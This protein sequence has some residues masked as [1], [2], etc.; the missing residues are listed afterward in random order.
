MEY[1]V[2]VG[3]EVHVE[4]ATQS[5]IFCSCSTAFGAPPNTQCCP[6]CLGLP[7]ALPQ[8]NEKVLDYSILAGLATHCRIAE[9][10]QFDRKHYFYPDLPKAYQI[11]QYEMPLCRDGYLKVETDA[12]E[13]IIRIERIHMEEDAGKLVHQQAG[14]TLID[15]NRCG[16]PL[17]EIVS[18][19]DMNSAQE[20]VAYLK[21]LRSVLVYAG[22]TD[23]NMSQG[24]F[25]ADINL[26]LR[27]KGDSALGTRTEIKN[28]N[29]FGYVSKAIAYEARRQAELLRQGLVVEQ[30]TRRFDA[31]SGTTRSLRQK[32]EAA[33][34]RFMP[35]PDLPPF[36][37]SRARVEAL[38]SSMPLLPDERKKMY[39][40]TYQLSA[41]HS[42]QLILEKEV[43]DLFEAAAAQSRYP[44]TV[45]SL[46]LAE[47]LRLYQ[48][49]QG[50]PLPAGELAA[51]A[52]C[53]G[54]GDIHSGAAREVLGKIWH[55]GGAAREWIDRLGLHQIQD[56]RQLGQIAA[57]VLEQNP[58]LAEDY[59]SGKTRAL[60]A[61][62]G[63][64]MAQT[65][66][67][68]NP[69]LLQNLLLEML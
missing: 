22:I 63:K 8:F 26:S 51:L 62:M 12:G 37:L 3:I 43:A 25:R 31:A 46:L 49:E 21:K 10:T 47:V 19:P 32:G 5:K 40:E 36:A 44:Q 28:I 68:A 50:L 64:A 14:S 48:P 17:I 29:S 35:E 53:T 67:R 59:R 1:E 57:Q 39:R 38:Q 30:E 18:R 4:L 61:L 58:K 9:V 2:V 6:V 60:K 34:Y 23:G 45:A 55:H 33:D 56:A 16:V 27:K 7:G 69:V 24:S 13:K 54:D 65:Q 52:D 20:A 41:Y 42:E 66:G 15:L 11:S